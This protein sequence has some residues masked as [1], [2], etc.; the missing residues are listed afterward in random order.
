MNRSMPVTVAAVL[1][2]LSSAYSVVFSIPVLARGVQS[3]TETNDTPPYFIMVLGLILGVLGI[4]A[5]W[6][7]WRNQRWG[8]ILTIAVIAIGALSA[9]PGIFFAPTTA[10][11][12]A[13]TVTVVIDIL[14]IVLVLLP[15][16]SPATARA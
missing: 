12:I 4:V 5:A 14:I 3:V 9:L 7:L 15:N 11:W 1:T 10:L 2:F 6:G 13:A 16:R 8:K